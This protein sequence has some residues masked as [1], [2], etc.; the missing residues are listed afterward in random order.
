ME[1]R[2]LVSNVVV[3]EYANLDHVNELLRMSR[4]TL[5]TLLEQKTKGPVQVY[6]IGCKVNELSEENFMESLMLYRTMQLEGV[7]RLVPQVGPHVT[8]MTED[9]VYKGILARKLIDNDFCESDNV[10]YTTCGK[11]E[12]K[13]L[14]PLVSCLILI[15]GLRA[16]SAVT[17]RGKNIHIPHNSSSWFSRARALERGCGMGDERADLRTARGARDEMVLFQ[18]EDGT[19]GISIRERQVHTRSQTSSTPALSSNV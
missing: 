5:G 2:S 7:T 1:D 17:S 14:A 19:H 13:Y 3:Y 12:L 8:R 15:L 18:R 9:D 10:L 6:R 11:Y 16:W 4:T